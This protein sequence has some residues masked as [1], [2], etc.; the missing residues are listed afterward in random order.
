[1]M[2]NSK[3]I[4]SEYFLSIGISNMTHLVFSLHS[5]IVLW[6]VPS[7]RTLMKAMKLNQDPYLAIIVL[8]TTPLNDIKIVTLMF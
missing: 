5:P 2:L 7:K 3:Q 8:R 4:N 6:N 1:M